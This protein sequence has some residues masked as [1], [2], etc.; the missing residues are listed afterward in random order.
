MLLQGITNI[1]TNIINVISNFS[2]KRNWKYGLRQKY[3]FGVLRGM[4]YDPNDI[5]NAL[6]RMELAKIV[7]KIYKY[8]YVYWFISKGYRT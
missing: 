8:G 4:G 3:L 1:E 5:S 6:E 2:R 7:Y